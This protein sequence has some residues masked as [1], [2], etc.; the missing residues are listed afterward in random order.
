MSVVSW[1]PSTSFSSIFWACKDLESGPGIG[2]TCFIPVSSV[3][4]DCGCRVSSCISA[5]VI[6]AFYP[7]FEV[8][9]SSSC[10]SKVWT[11]EV[12]VP[13]LVPST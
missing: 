2:L 13:L 3:S 7:V 12:L 9:T 10:S 5:G 11:G 1:A 8:V 6:P 4:K